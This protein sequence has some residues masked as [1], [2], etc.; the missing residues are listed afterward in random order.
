MFDSNVSTQADSIQDQQDVIQNFKTVQIVLYSI[1]FILSVTGNGILAFIMYKRIRRKNATNFMILVLSLSDLGVSLASIPFDII[2][3][4]YPDTWLLGPVLCKVLWPLQTLFFI[5]LVWTLLLLSVI[6]YKEV[7]MRGHTDIKKTK[8]AVISA[9]F[10]SLIVVIPYVTALE[11]KGDSC[12]EKW[13]SMGYRKA[14]T[15]LLFI[16]QYIIPL[17]VMTF[18]YTCVANK[19]QRGLS[20]F[21]QRLENS[22]LLVQHHIKLTRMI[23]VMVLVFAIAMLPHHIVWILVDFSEFFDSDYF[24]II[25][26]ASYLLMFASIVANPIIFGTQSDEFI[27]EF[28][29]ILGKV[30]RSDRLFHQETIRRDL[31]NS[32]HHKTIPEVYITYPSEVDLEQSTNEY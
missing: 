25:N 13:P 8:I 26:K 3:L 6:R 23:F 31:L 29:I 16:A 15:V 22:K 32:R 17:T 20:T 7:Y 14:Y 24:N 27:K 28:K 10:G 1:I 2:E 12:V 11:F 4:E 21:S 19:L 30:A 18:C 5:V 9:W